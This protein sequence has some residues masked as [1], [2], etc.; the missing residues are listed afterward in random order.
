M[1][2]EEDQRKLPGRGNV[3]LNVS[4]VR[5][6][7]ERLVRREAQGAWKS[8][9]ICIELRGQESAQKLKIAESKLALENPLGRSFAVVPCATSQEAHYSQFP[10][11]N[12]ITSLFENQLFEVVRN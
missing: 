10:H 3:R 5:E 8:R 1:Q 4:R 9:G 11:R 7:R 2:S 12:V 6:G